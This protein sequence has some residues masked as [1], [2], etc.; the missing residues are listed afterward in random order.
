MEKRPHLQNSLVPVSQ[1]YDDLVGRI[2]EAAAVPDLWPAVLDRI[3]AMTGMVGGMLFTVDPHHTLRQIVS[4]ALADLATAF[5]R[6]GWA[7]RNSR[8]AKLAPMNYP[9][10]ASDLDL[11]TP[12][13]L[14]RDPFYTDLLRPHGVGWGAGTIIRAPTEDILVFTVEGDRGPMQREAVDFL[15][16]LRPHLARAAL[17]SA[18]LHLERVRSAIDALEQMAIPACILQRNGCVLLANARFQNIGPQFVARANDRVCLAIRAANY[19]F[20]RALANMDAGCAVDDVWSIPIPRIGEHPPAIVH[21]LPV[22]GAA[23]DVFARG[24]AVMVVTSFA[25]P[26]APQAALLHGLFDL[27]PAEARLAAQVGSGLSPRESA[28]KLGIT[29]ETARTVLKR[30]FSKTG[31]S[32]QSELAALLTKPVLR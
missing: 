5:Q 28:E 27:T 2:Y 21:L 23:R 7:E 30:V 24:L 19:L 26:S 16:R 15:D 9:G 32:R 31:V 13:E 25:P 18:R 4:P 11:F 22:R 3:A 12:E 10:F 14:E 29:E 17:L 1:D 20:M 8:A 6:D